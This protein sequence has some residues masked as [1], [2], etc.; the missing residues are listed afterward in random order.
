[1]EALLPVAFP[2]TSLPT[3]AV[4]EPGLRVVVTGCIETVLVV[5]VANIYFVPVA[6]DHCVSSG[7]GYWIGLVHL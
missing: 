4:A 2:V 6:Q 5:A 3:L 7:L 1:M